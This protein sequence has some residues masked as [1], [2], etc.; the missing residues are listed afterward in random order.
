MLI[1]EQISFGL[2]LC[3]TVASGAYLYAPA[4][5]FE[6]TAFRNEISSFVQLANLIN[7]DNHFNE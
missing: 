4:M 2:T 6:A 5:L 1:Y 7:F 3:F